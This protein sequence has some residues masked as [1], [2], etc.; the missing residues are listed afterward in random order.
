M[1]YRARCAA[2]AC[3]ERIGRLARLS[4]LCVGYRRRQTGSVCI[5]AHV[6]FSRTREWCRATTHR[7]P[8]P[9]P[10]QPLWREA[11]RGAFGPVYYAAVPPLMCARA[12]AALVGSHARA[13]AR[14]TQTRADGGWKLSL[15]AHGVLSREHWR[16]GGAER[17]APGVPQPVEYPEY[18]S[19]SRRAC[20]GGRKTGRCA[21]ERALHR[22]CAARPAACRPAHANH[23]TCDVQHVTC[24]MQHATCDVQHTTCNARRVTYDTAPRPAACPAQC[25]GHFRPLAEYPAPAGVPSAAPQAPTLAVRR[26]AASVGRSSSASASVSVG[27]SVGAA[28]DGARNVAAVVA[29]GQTFWRVFVPSRWPPSGFGDS[30]GGCGT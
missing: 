24:N 17:A 4:V 26:R 13:S 25:A 8:G 20:D 30:C 11:Q 23:T 2:L 1:L 12:R 29:T 14:A 21:R 19:H 9:L 27:V 6:S 7:P 10:L 18:G 28:G 15:Q 16:A 5:A 3:S 22:G